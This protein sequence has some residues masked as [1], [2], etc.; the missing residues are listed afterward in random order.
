[1]P[2]LLT[3]SAMDLAA[4]M[5]R[6]ALDPVQVVEAH[7]QR[8]RQVDPQLN[9][10]VAERFDAAR[11]EARAAALRIADAG[12]DDALPPLL[13]VP[14]TV[15]EFVAVQGMPWTAG[16][17]ARR[18]HRAGGDA[19]VV[20]RLRA[21][22]AIVLGATNM[23]EG[24]LWMEARNPLYGHTLNPWDPE[25]TAGGSSGGCGALVAC[26]AVPFS[27]GAD[28]GGSIR[29]PAAFCGTL[30]H[31]PSGRMVPTTGHL[32]APH[33]LAKA[34]L[35]LGPLVRRGED[36][37]PLLRILAGPD[38]L[39]PVARAFPLPADDTLPDP[40]T[41]HVYPV[42]DH[43]GVAIWP[44]ARRAVRRAARALEALG[45]TVHPPDALSVG[46]GVLPWSNAL[47]TP[48]GERYREILGDGHSIPLARELLLRS[49]GRGAHSGLPLVVCVLEALLGGIPND[50]ERNLVRLM[51][52]GQALESRMG[53]RSVIL[54][55]PWSRPAP[56]HRAA[57]FG[58]FDWACTAVFNALE[59]PATVVPVGF[60]RHG[61]PTAVQVVGRRGDD[62]L[63]IGVA[64]L[65]ERELGGW[66]MAEPRPS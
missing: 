34:L 48:G 52:R 29:I 14:C 25:R 47:M 38:G 33:G 42:E 59:M 56:R 57:F 30:G 2:S 18:G 15:K 1:M 20:K 54:H 6:G 21:A 27:V 62:A 24:G 4:R 49:L 51:Q 53:P 36:L 45:A 66:V 8:I 10:L 35:C 26:G 37:L 55:P 61:L 60:E 43:M 64:R 7:I 44:E 58:P 40:G 23:A 28:I 3:A 39:D 11:A 31:K 13:G 22:G 12:P 32:P 65:I 19:T 16:I 5:R 9:A 17:A 41:L 46:N 63:T 50:Y